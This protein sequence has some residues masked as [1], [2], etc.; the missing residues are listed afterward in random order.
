MKATAANRELDSR[1]RLEVILRSG[2]DSDTLMAE[3]AV[4]CNADPGA[5]WETLALVDQFHRRGI[6]SQDLYR[7]LKQQTE[8]LA[9]GRPNASEGRPTPPPAL[10]SPAFAVPVSDKADVAGDSAAQAYRLLEPSPEPTPST[11]PTPQRATRSVPPA[12]G[13]VL[14]KRYLLEAP[15]DYGRGV[16]FQAL[17]S[18]RADLPAEEQRVAVRFPAASTDAQREFYRLQSLA[19]PNVARVHEF[20]R[21]GDLAFYTMELIR[22]RVLCDL[23]VELPKLPMPMPEALAIIRDVG[24]ALVHAHAHRVVH[25]HLDAHSVMITDAGDV[26]VLDFDAP[27]ESGVDPQPSDDLQALAVLAYEL[28]AGQHPFQRRSTITNHPAGLRVRRPAGLSR[29]QWRTLQ[30]GLAWTRKKRG[31]TLASWLAGLELE[32]APPHLP[33]LTQLLRL[34]PAP[35]WRPGAKIALAV[36]VALAAIGLFAMAQP[37]MLQA[38]LDT[39]QASLS[40]WQRQTPTVAAQAVV[41]AAPAPV[42][43]APGPRIEAPLPVRPPARGAT[44][45]G[46]RERGIALEGE[47]TPAADAAR[48][49]LVSSDPVALPANHG[50]LEFPYDTLVVAPGDSVARV[51]VRRVNGTQGEVAFSWWT[52]NGTARAGEDFALLNEQTEIIP[53]GQDSA[54]LLIPLVDDSTR[55]DRTSTFFVNIEHATGGATLGENTHLVVTLRR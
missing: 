28:L 37:A 5:A 9:L 45:N 8:V 43:A 38:W 15:L 39:A 46:Q 44:R 50:R 24:A 19:H 7:T 4:V 20:D 55:G 41:T 18:F 33:R 47:A 27:S 30:Y 29:R 13:R 48:D 35:G 22:G 10:V 11:S 34:R 17:D 3:I 26:R 6:L 16:V 12:V 23:L 14:R 49:K 52:E 54:T 53:E 40:S 21:D 2:A 42:A 36:G 1:Q 51:V 25:G 32:R 31:R